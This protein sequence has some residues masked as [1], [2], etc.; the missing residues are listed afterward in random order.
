[1]TFDEFLRSAE[2]A[3]R[4]GDV[5]LARDNYWAA[6]QI[7][8]ADPLVRMRLGLTLKQLGRLHDAL[9]E[10]TTVTRLSPEYGEAWKEKGVI[11]GMIARKIDEGDRPRWLHDGQAS[12]ERATQ[13]IPNDFDAWAS[14][15]GVLKNVKGDRTAAAANY[16]HAAEIS[17][18]HPYPLLNAIRLEAEL[19]GQL[20]LT[21]HADQLEAAESL[22]RGQMMASPATD[23]PWSHFDVAEICA[24]RG[25]QAGFLAALRTG[26]EHVTADYQAETFRRSIQDLTNLGV[27]LPGV[28]EALQLIDAKISSMR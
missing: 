4:L 18:G 3:L 6:S 26:L 19:T 7:Q 22:R 17:D 13:L 16:A 14:L 9:D 20:D 8:P 11:E 5:E 1:V 23:A 15:A 21:A 24:Y 12:L 10:F 27:Q 25:D 28:D 2:E